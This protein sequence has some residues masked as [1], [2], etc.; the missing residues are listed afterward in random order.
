MESQRAPATEQVYAL[1]LTLSQWLSKSPWDNMLQGGIRKTELREE[2]PM[3]NMPPLHF[4]NI[5]EYTM[6]HR[7]NLKS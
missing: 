3:R 2:R 1:L 4:L 5:N 7:Q 6:D